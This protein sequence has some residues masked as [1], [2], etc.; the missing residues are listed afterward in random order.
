MSPPLKDIIIPTFVRVLDSN[1]IPKKNSELTNYIINFMG[2]CKNNARTNFGKISPQ[3]FGR[4]NGDWFEHIFEE[5]LKKKIGSNN[6]LKFGRGHKI[7]EIKG[8]EKVS[9]IPAP[10]IILK[11]KTD[12]RSIISLK[13]GLRHDR[14]YEVGYEAYAIKDWIKKNSL[15]SVNVF[16]FAND[17]DSGYESRLQTMSKVPALDD[18]FYL[19]H[20]NLSKSLKKNVKSLGNLLGEIQ[21]IVK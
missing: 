5:I 11:N 13:W 12:L 7:K 14:M 4:M 9:W 16:L 3:Q 6:F 21:T 1:P 20:E 17:T 18:V 10:D 8:F 2:K 15:T 19:R